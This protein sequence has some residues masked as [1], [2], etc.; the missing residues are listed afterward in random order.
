MNPDRL[1][2]LEDERGFLLR[3]LADLEREHEAGD[4]DQHDFEVLRDGYTA[5]AA[6]VLRSIDEGRA[7][8]PARR[9]SN[10]RA[11]VATVAAVLA[12]AVLSGWLLARSSGQR[13]ADQTMTGGQDVDNVTGLLVEARREFLSGNLQAS[14]TIYA[15]VAELDPTNSEA[16]TYTAWLLVVDSQNKLGASAETM[17][18]AALTGLESIIADDP[19]Y[20]DAHCF[21]AIAEALFTP[22]PDQALVVEQRRLCEANNPPSELRGLVD[23][24]LGPAS[25]PSASTAPASSVPG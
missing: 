19:S 10:P 15:Q 2:E 6:N 3:S 20:A 18:N 13:L 1:A 25:D 17:V 11:V 7:A 22:E 8:L 4:V 23:E 9:V 12:L 5:R 14:A 16:R 24:Q 21:Y